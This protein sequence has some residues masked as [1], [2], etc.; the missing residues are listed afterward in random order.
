M[1]G[2]RQQRPPAQFRHVAPVVTVLA[3]PAGATN[4]PSLTR[5]PN[6]TTQISWVYGTLESAAQLEGPWAAVPGAVSPYTMPV[7]GTNGFFR[8]R[9]F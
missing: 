4:Q 9:L 8:V 5:L 1:P 7:S 3:V 6:G 2:Q